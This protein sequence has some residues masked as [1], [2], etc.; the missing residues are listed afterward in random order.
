[1]PRALVVLL[2][3]SSSTAAR[4]SVIKPDEAAVKAA[5]AA[6]PYSDWNVLLEKYVDGKGRVD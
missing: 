3:L 1:M 2:A 6:F 5:P 4:A